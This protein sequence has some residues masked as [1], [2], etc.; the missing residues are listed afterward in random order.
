MNVIL[1]L[2]DTLRRDH[3]SPYGSSLVETPNF[4]RL[5][6]RG[7][8]FDKA[9]LGSYPCMPARRDLWTGRYEFPWR[10]WGPLEWNDHS[11]PEVLAHAGVKS[12]LVTDHYHLFEHGSGNYHFG[13]DSWE[14]IRGQEKDM[15][16]L[17]T[18]EVLWPGP[19]YSKVH[20]GW[21]QY[22]A[23]TARWRQG[24]NWASEDHTFAAQT[25]RAATQWVDEHRDTSP[26]FLMIDCFDP[27]EPFDPP[28]PYRQQYEDNP[29]KDRMTWPIYGPAN[30]YTE[31]EL[32]DV[33][34]LYRG[35]VALVDTWLGYFLDR[36]ERLGRFDDTL[37]LL[38]TDHGHLFGEHGMIGKPST[39]HGDSNM[40]EELVHIPLLASHPEGK[41]GQRIA[42]LAQPVDL[43]PT[44]L[45]ALGVP[46]PA[47]GHGQDLTP[48]ILGETE[49]ERP[50]A[51]FAKFGE[52]INLTDGTYTLFQWP[53]SDRNEPLY[54]YSAQPPDF[55]KPRGFGPYE[56]DRTRFP[57]DWIRGPMRTALY[58]VTED[59]HQQHDLAAQEPETVRRLQNALRRW[60]IEL[61]APSEQLRRLG[62]EE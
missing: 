5:A 59:P 1:I 22:W 26:F 53:E 19:E 51:C 30:R 62:L 6:D 35:E 36:L 32:R 58:N 8:T 25:F 60:L 7:T 23:N 45:N 44:I 15:W 56:P 38:T 21:R 43:F 18:G 9:Y 34:G 33:R 28:A 2:I 24:L 27:H 40:Y 54:W 17:A 4:Q 14:F 29:G 13:F 37:I 3:L 20:R 12:G 49:V 41:V 31:D 48:V 42:D 16:G 55:L 46:T 10:G 52:A 11:L 57:I 47:G 61:Q 39:N 50:A